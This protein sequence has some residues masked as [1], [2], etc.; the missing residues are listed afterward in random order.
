VS[1]Q[2]QDAKKTVRRYVYKNQGLY[3]LIDRIKLWPGRS[4]ILHGVKSVTVGDG[5]IDVLTHCGESFT[6][7]DSRNSRSARWLRNRWFKRACPRCGV[8]AWKLEKYNST[9]FLDAQRKGERR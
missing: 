2:P 5:R 3:A 6:V 4:G 7:W 1:E 9:V 8:P